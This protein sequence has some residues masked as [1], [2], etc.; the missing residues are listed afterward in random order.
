MSWAKLWTIGFVT[1]L[2]VGHITLTF[3]PA[4]YPPLDFLD[5]ART[6]GPCGVPKTDRSKFDK[7]FKVNL[8]LFLRHILNVPN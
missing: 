6:I 8:F 3:P 4:R 7:N 5:T 1:E 2:V